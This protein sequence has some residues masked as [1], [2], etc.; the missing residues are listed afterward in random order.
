MNKAD[1]SYTGLNTAVNAAKPPAQ[2]LPTSDKNVPTVMCTNVRSAF[3]KLE[4][5]A[6][7]VIEEKIDVAFLTEIWM[8]FSNPLHCSQLERLFQLKGLETIV[9]WQAWGWCCHIS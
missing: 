2:S 8:D 5:I 6:N 1:N 4:S 3:S 7:E 9:T